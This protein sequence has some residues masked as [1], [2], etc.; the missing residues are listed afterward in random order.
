MLGGRS[1]GILNGKKPPGRESCL[2][3]YLTFWWDCGFPRRPNFSQSVYYFQVRDVFTLVRE[4]E[5]VMA[6]GGNDKTQL[7]GVQIR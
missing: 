5:A 4:R 2:D 3:F 1:R 7:S 6:A